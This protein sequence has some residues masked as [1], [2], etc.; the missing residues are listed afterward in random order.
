LEFRSVLR[1]SN[2]K[3]NLKKIRIAHLTSVHPAFYVRIF[4]KE[5]RTL[6]ESGY[7]VVLVVPHERDDQVD[8]VRIHAVPKPANRLSRMLITTFHVLRAALSENAEIYHFHDPELIPVGLILRLIGKAVVYDVHEDVPKDVL[9]KSYIRSSLA[10]RLI[11]RLAEITE[12]LGSGFFSAVVAATP[13]IA[14]RFPREKTVVVENF[15]I[16]GELEVPRA[17]SYQQRPLQVVYIGDITRIRGISEMVKA[18]VLVPEKIRP[19]LALAGTFDPPDLED[20]VR[21]LPGWTATIFLGWQ[22]RTQ[23]SKLLDRSRVGMLLF[24]PVPNHIE[25]QPNK[26]YEYMSM[27]LPVIASDFPLWRQIIGH[28]GC[29]LLVDPLNPEAIAEAISWLLD[30]PEQAEA[31]GYRGRQ[32][33][34][35]N[36]N[37]DNEARKLVTLYHQLSTLSAV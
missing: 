22:S 24:H 20:Q 30:H 5:C 37:W 32:A 18:I 14:K 12:H 10:R 2:I 23:L 11:A 9:S 31:M 33:V 4:H 17:S 27:G 13:A 7:D 15:P 26:L 19:E 16:L 28:A 25:A 1:D 21:R 35:S 3:V 36:Y 29:G 34:L 6:A 8:G